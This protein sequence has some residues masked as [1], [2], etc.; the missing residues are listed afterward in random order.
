LWQS[1]NRSS[2]RR[3]ALALALIGLAVFMHWRE[4]NNSLVQAVPLNPDDASEIRAGALAYRG[5]IEIP[6][7]GQDI[8]GLSALRWDERSGRLLALTDDARWVWITPLE[9]DDRL[10][11]LAGFEAGPLLGLEGEQLRG[12]EAGDS[13]GLTRSQAGGWLVSFERDHRIWR[14]PRLDAVPEPTGIDP[15]AIMA[16]SKPMAARRR[17]R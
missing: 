1:A 16:R 8:G 17:S 6:R 4:A 3:G 5:G 13:E 10:V 15:V 7:M 11:G 2:L 14:Y 12:K 9:E